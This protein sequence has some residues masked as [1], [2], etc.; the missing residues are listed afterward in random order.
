MTKVSLGGGV[1]TKHIPLRMTVG[2]PHAPTQGRG[3]VEPGL[4]L[5]S[6]QV[7]RFPCGGIGSGM[8]GWAGGLL[9]PI[10]HRR[11]ETTESWGVKGYTW[12]FDW[13]GC[14]CL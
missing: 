14:Q 3:E 7:L 9:E 8:W 2:S 10:P 1:H 4:P 13:V 11:Q 5:P 12:I 6:L